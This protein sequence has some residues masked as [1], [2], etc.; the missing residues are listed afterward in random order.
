MTNLNNNGPNVDAIKKLY[1]TN[2]V[3][4]I[5]FDHFATKQRN[6]SATTVDRLRA[7]LV[8]QG[9]EVSYNEIR[10]F[11]RKLANLKCGDYKIGRRGWDSRLEWSVGLVSL[12]QAAAGRHSE[13]TRLT[14]EEAAESQKEDTEELAAAEVPVDTQDMKVS[15]PLRPTRSVEFVLPKNLTAREAHRLAEFIKTLPFEEAAAA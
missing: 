9:H 13:I 1:T 14:E 4:K 12:G 10:D 11:L 6:K 3:A 5:A 2:R 15:Y 7:V 8:A